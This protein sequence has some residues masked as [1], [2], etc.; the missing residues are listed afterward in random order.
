MASR[1]RA[2]SKRASQAAARL[3]DGWD[4]EDVSDFADGMVVLG[5]SYSRLGSAI[6]AGYYNRIRMASGAEG[7]F[8]AAAIDAF[9]AAAMASASTAIAES[10]A[11]GTATVGLVSLAGA[12][13]DREIKGAID[14]CIHENVR[15]DPAKPR[16]AFVPQG[17]A[18]AFCEMRAANGLTYAD[19]DITPSHDFCTCEPTP[20]FDKDG[21]EGY[22]PKAY[23]EKYDAAREALANGDI[24]DELKERIEQQKDAKGKA[25][26]KTKQILA[27]MREQNGIR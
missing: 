8:S 27:V 13:L 4:G 26:D 24:S 21:I 20:V 12:L 25:Y 17:D 10:V 23:E 18:C 1:N 6:A 3:V 7:A 19:D 9:D 2:L 5:R 11:A 14:N 22:D 15:R 16:Y